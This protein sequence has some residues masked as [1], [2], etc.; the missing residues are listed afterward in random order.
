MPAAPSTP[1]HLGRPPAPPTPAADHYT[2][3][4]PG[5]NAGPIYCSD[6]TAALVEHLCGV[7][8]E[9]L[10]VVPMDTPTGIE[11]GRGGLPKIATVAG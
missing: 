7:G 8:R 2:G 1:W 10:R 4:K 11:G 5:W 6:V 3:L 9:W